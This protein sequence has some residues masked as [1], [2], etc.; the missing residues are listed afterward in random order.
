MSNRYLTTGEAA[1]QD[2]IH[3]IT[4]TA[5]PHTQDMGHRMK[6]YSIQM[7]LR[8]VCLIVFVVVDNIW[9]RGVA[10]AGVAILPWMAVMLA[11]SGA[12]RSAR[13]SHYY[14]PPAAPALAAVPE[15]ARPAEPLAIDFVLEGEFV[16]GH[17]DDDPARPAPGP[18]PAPSGGPASSATV[19]D[20]PYRSRGAA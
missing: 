3:S 13:T 19:E 10:I 12:D 18:A 14:E 15:P 6:V 9:V 4:A 1:G 20:D 7:A 17:G 2:E 11:N 16:A 5:A 8:V